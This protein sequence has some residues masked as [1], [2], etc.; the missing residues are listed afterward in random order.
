MFHFHLVIEIHK[1]KADFP[2]NIN[3]FLFGA[4]AAIS[5]QIHIFFFFY[6]LN[7]HPKSSY[8]VVYHHI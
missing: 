8:K 4:L 7:H 6:W 3:I 5:K 1:I 2:F